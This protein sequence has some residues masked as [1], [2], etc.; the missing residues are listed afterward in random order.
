MP[1]I[2]AVKRVSLKRN[3]APTPRYTLWVPVL[4]AAGLSLVWLG[5]LALLQR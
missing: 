3:A 4:V 2:D 1:L 5:L